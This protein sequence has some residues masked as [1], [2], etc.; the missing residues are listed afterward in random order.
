VAA[1]L[2]KIKNKYKKYRRTD[3]QP[4]LQPDRPTDRTTKTNIIPEDKLECF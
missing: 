4:N 2:E 3:R 1:A